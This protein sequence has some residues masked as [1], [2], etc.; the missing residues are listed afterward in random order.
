MNDTNEITQASPDTEAPAVLLEQY[1]REANE[2][3]TEAQ[4]FAKAAKSKTTEA[5][6]AALLSGQALS[7]ARDLCKYGEWYPW[8]GKNCPNISAETARKW[9]AIANHNASWDLIEGKT[10]QQ[11]YI[12]AGLVDKKEPEAR[13]EKSIITR[14]QEIL[15]LLQ[16]KS[17]KINVALRDEEE[18]IT[19]VKV[20][21]EIRDLSARMIESTS[22]AEAAV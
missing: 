22:A 10:I 18:R 20:C 6:K 19:F 5:V 2:R 14:F 1:A 4:E 12:D 16:G 8:L 11:L 13:A 21:T 15:H 9:I 7:R 3:H 17:D